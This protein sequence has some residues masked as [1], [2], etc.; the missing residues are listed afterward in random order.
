M[1]SEPVDLLWHL[2][3]LKKPVKGDIYRIPLDLQVLDQNRIKSF[4]KSESDLMKAKK[5]LSST[6]DLIG[7]N[8][9]FHRTVYYQPPFIEE[10]TVKG[11]SWV[12]A[13]LSGWDGESYVTVQVMLDPFSFDRSIK[14]QDMNLFK[15]KIVNCKTLIKDKTYIGPSN[16]SNELTFD[17]FCQC[18]SLGNLAHC[19]SLN[20]L[21]CTDLEN[22]SN[23][24][25]ISTMLY[26]EGNTR[27]KKFPNL[28]GVI[29]NVELKRTNI[30]V[31]CFPHSVW[32]S[33]SIN[34]ENC[35]EYFYKTYFFTH[36]KLVKD[37][38]NSPLE[39]L[40]VIMNRCRYQ[41]ERDMILTRFNGLPIWPNE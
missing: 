37:I 1:S 9:F 6:L 29:S 30:N 4:V 14:I 23:L 10:E 5:I 38:I 39:D 8:G 24:T 18:K 22:A 26:V 41:V 20:L 3:N 19:E 13:D 35:Y 25:K 7:L 34:G 17:S 21:D 16:V 27:I 33:F 2:D 11:S 31:L 15:K 40:P 12:L 28:T 36:K 32:T